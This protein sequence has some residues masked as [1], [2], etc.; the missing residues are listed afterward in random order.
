MIIGIKYGYNHV[1]FTYPS[2]MSA[3]KNHCIELI[4]QNK[5]E[6]KLFIKFIWG[7]KIYQLDELN[8]ELLEAKKLLENSNFL[9]SDESYNLLDDDEKEDYINTGK[10]PLKYFCA[11][12][13]NIA[14]IEIFLNRLKI[15]KEEDE[16]CF[17][18]GSMAVRDDMIEEYGW[19][20]PNKIPEEIKNM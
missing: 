7:I 1:G 12:N 9:L 17:S 18:I 19:D 2:I 11:L 20:W 15:A 10:N 4:G 13:T 6:F 8:N 3:F 14:F 16:E 5:N